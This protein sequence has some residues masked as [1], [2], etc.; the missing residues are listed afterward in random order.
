MWKRLEVYYWSESHDIKM[1]M[2]VTHKVIL[3]FEHIV[4]VFNRFLRLSFKEKAVAKAQ[5]PSQIR[6][7]E[8]AV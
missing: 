8:N 2:R 6:Y 3:G 4:R 5:E 7:H 1:L